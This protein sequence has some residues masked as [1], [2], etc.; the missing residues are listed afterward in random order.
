MKTLTLTTV[1]AVAAIGAAS[2]P[3]PIDAKVVE[4]KVTKVESPAFEGRTFG[5]VG[6]YEQITARARIAVD[7]A[8]RHNAGIVDVAAAPRN[9]RGQVE[10]EA[11][12]TILKPIDMSKANG[13]MF[14]DVNNR[15]NKLALGWINDAVNVNGLKAAGD[16][17]NGFLMN[18]G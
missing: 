6:A 10:F 18:S 9:A 15:G 7:P 1:A 11:D 13:R 4:F 17:G 8:D 16:A 12:V 5:A 2:L 3:S 14:Y